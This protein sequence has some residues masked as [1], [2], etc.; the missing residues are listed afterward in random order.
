M[1]ERYEICIQGHVDAAWATYF[2][3]MQLSHRPDGT[4]LLAGPMADQPALLG[5]LMRIGSLGIPILT[6]ENIDYRLPCAEPKR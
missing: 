6:V 3:N 5:L 1:P 2:E 4:T